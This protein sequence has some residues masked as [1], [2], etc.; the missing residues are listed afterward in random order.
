M[1]QFINMRAV[2]DTAAVGIAGCSN[3]NAASRAEVGEQTPQKDGRYRFSC[4]MWWLQGHI[5]GF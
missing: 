1:T 3:L 5:N 4:D 2:V